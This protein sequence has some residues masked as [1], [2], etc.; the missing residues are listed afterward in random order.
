MSPEI[1]NRALN[2]PKKI[3]ELKNQTPA[4]CLLQTNIFEKARIYRL[5]WVRGSQ[6]KN[7]KGKT[8]KNRTKVITQ[9]HTKSAI[10]SYTNFPFREKGRTKKKMSNKDIGVF[11]GVV[12]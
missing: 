1:Q 8:N 3:S 6:A 4:I 5:R 7:Y 11:A 10:Y 9:H 2:G 12:E